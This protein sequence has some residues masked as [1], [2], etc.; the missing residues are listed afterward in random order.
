MPGHTSKEKAKRITQPKPR[1]RNKKKTS[2]KKG[3]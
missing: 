1:V 2:H 3:K